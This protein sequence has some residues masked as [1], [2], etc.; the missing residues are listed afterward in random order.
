MTLT[1][2]IAVNGRP[3]AQ[4]MAHNVS[5]LS[6]V[7]T[8]IVGANETSSGVTGSPARKAMFEI[9]GHDR[10]QSAWALVEKIA[11]GFLAR[12]G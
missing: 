2:T 1:V 11:A 5:D 8:Y 7:S 10:R 12:A 3:I 9:H 4:A 6:D